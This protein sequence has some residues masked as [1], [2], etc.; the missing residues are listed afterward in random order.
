MFSFASKASFKIEY[1]D[2]NVVNVLK[3]GPD[4]CYLFGIAAFPREGKNR[5]GKEI[6][7]YKIHFGICVERKLASALENSGGKTQK[8]G[9]KTSKNEKES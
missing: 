7:F 4:N 5:A 3:L 6:I 2:K 1:V 8:E 9:D